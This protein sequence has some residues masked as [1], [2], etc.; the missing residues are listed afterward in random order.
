[1][2]RL[3]LPALAALLA[4]CAAVAQKP[5]AEVFFDDFSEPD[6]AALR[7]SGWVLRTEA[8]HP[9]IDGARW[10]PSA[11]ELVPDPE[12]PGNRLL[13]LNARTDGSGAGT[14]QTQLCQQ[15]KFL[16]G[17]YAARVRFYDRPQSGSP[18]DPV[19]QSFYAANPLRFDFDPEYSELDWEY[20]GQGAWGN[21]KPRIYSVTWQTARLDP[22]T[23]YNQ[24]HEE[25]GALGGWHVLLMQVADGHTHWFMDGRKVAEH[26]GR[27][28]P[29]S[30]MAISFNLWF[31]P[32][33]L[34]P[35]GAQPRA[36]REDVDW[37]FH[38]R[39]TVLS[40]AEVDAQVQRLRRDGQAHLDTVP[41]AEPVLESRCNL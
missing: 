18:G 37:V 21:D 4:G 33:G 17:T 36:Y 29:A 3:V 15:R 11:I 6:L 26:G 32:D 40:P 34:L 38:A 14:V 25:M 31:H 39:N 30:M 19:I 23:S 9:G 1:M 5:P 22:W 12:Q 27:N 41:P 7:A 24:A 13:R 28:Y 8:G 35:A 20:V 10:D 16:A 2:R